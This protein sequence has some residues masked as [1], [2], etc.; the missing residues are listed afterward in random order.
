MMERCREMP[1]SSLPRQ[2]VLLNQAETALCSTRLLKPSHLHQKRRSMST[3]TEK[4]GLSLNRF[5]VSISLREP[6]PPQMGAGWPQQALL[7]QGSL[8]PLSP[9]SSLR[10]QAIPF[11]SS[12]SLSLSFA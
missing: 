7:A 1:V 12:G 5:L 4:K 3:L 11:P 10:V 2:A 9:L 8:L 6:D